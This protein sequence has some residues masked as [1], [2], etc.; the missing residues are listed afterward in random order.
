[1]ETGRGNQVTP[2]YLQ[3]LISKFVFSKL[4]TGLLLLPSIFA[5]L[6]MALFT[7]GFSQ[8]L[9]LG[10]KIV[11]GEISPLESL[12]IA[13]PMLWGAI[14]LLGFTIASM[15]SVYNLLKNIK[16]HFY[17][18]G[19]TLYYFAGGSS[20]EGAMQY[21]RSTLIRSTLPSPVTGMLLAFLTSGIAYPVILC[22]VE[23]AVREHAIVEEETLF[24]TKFT[25]EYK[26]FN[27]LIDFTLLFLTLG[28]Y[29]VYMSY[30]LARVFNAH[31]NNIHGSHPNPPTIPPHSVAIRELKPTMSLLVGLLLLSMGFNTI[32]SCFGL[33]TANYVVYSCGVLLSTL[34]LVRGTRKLTVSSILVVLALLYLLMIGGLLAGIAGY[35]T[36]KPL[37]DTIRRQIDVISSMNV[38]ELTTYI[39]VNNLVLSLPSIVPYI[40]GILMA[41]GVYNAG[42]VIGTVV[43]SGLRSLRD[44][45]LILAYPHAVLELSAY[46][47]LLTSSSLLGKWKK[48]AMLVTTGI[49]FLFT[50][51]LVE[52]LTIKHL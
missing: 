32:T 29:L 40:G 9:K 52:T 44:V 38:L 21:L 45:L 14:A 16:D 34:V 23:K 10:E 22:F 17:Q 30:R 13:Q 2:H 42:L 26:W 37:T 47:I 41:Q 24:K 50:A 48:Y 12:Y 39:F 7:V 15:V 27:M 36:Y 4:S 28:L 31:V 35:E 3:E 1:M 46:S 49:L 20:F 43:G 5:F 25:G 33:F 11:T 18:S 51:A 19:V 8:L 6:S